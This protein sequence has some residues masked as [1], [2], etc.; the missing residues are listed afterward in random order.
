M[1]A[2]STL[3]NC[4]DR[5]TAIVLQIADERRVVTGWARRTKDAALGRVLL[6]SV[7]EPAGNAELLLPEAHWVG[8]VVDG[9]E[10]GC[11]FC[12]LPSPT[13]AR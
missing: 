13:F 3:E 4:H 8:D 1:K 6:I 12:L 11:D 2:A 7:E 10:Y 9:S 5:R